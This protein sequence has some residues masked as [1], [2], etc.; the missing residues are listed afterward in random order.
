MAGS[1]FAVG[2]IHGQQWRL[3]NL[4]AKLPLT[5]DDLL[6]FV[7]DYIDRGPDSNGVLQFLIELRQSHPETVFLRGNHEEMMLNARRSRFN[8]ETYALWMGN[9]GAETLDS[10][11]RARPWWDRVPEDHWEFLEATSLEFWQ[12]PYAFVHAGF[13]PPNAVWIWDEDPRLWVREE[14]LN[15]DH[16]FGAKVV[17]GHTPQKSGKPL[18]KPNM[19]GIDTGAAYGGPLSAVKLS[20]DDPQSFELFQA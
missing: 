9:G 19:L 8:P 7:G 1:I 4:I 10:Y 14:F 6:V 5:P 2:D 17:F 12:G 15:S 11:P 13:L 18:A 20:L 16:D 3:L